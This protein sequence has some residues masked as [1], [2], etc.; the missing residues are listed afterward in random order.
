MTGGSATRARDIGA[1]ALLAVGL[2][3]PALWNC[4]P[5]IFPDSGTYLAIALG[6]DYAID[7]SSIYGFFLKPFVTTVPGLAGLWLGIVVQCLLLAAILWPAARLLTGSARTALVALGATILLSSLG[8]HAGQFMPDAFTGATV[9][10]GW[11][12]A[13]RDPGAAGA[14]SLWLAA[15]AAASM[16][17][18]HI[19]VLLAAAFAALLAEKLLGLGWTAFGRRALAA[20]AAAAAALLLQVGLNAAVLHRPAPAPMGSLF[21]YARLSEDGLIAPWLADHCG[22]DGPRRLCALAPSLP[23]GSQ[24]L[25]WGGAAS[26]ITDLVWHPR[27]EADRWPLIAEMGQ[28]NRGAIRDRPLAFLASSARGTLRQLVHFA[29]LDDECPVGCHDR[30]GGIAFTLTRYRPE[31]LPALDASRQVTDT[32]PKRLL[33][34]VTTPIAILAL[35]A[36]PFLMAA[37]WRRRDRDSLGLLAAIIAGLVTNAALAGALSDVHDRYQSRVVWLAPFAALLLL[38]RWRSNYRLIAVTVAA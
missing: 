14:P 34:A 19:P 7:R 28:A 38:A 32:T 1:I 11:L 2:L 18:T 13:R 26:P 24:Q 25:L 10:L 35:L 20:L 36:L 23:R 12:A 16:H 31:A 29:A 5:L 17:Y 37:A 4:F 8:W 33:R 6:H 15:I 9:L 27:V 21:L 3:S 30:R 22:R